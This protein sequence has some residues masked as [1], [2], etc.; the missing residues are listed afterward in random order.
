MICY[1]IT[2]PAFLGW[3][4]IGFTT[5]KEM[6]QRLSVY[7]TGT[8]FRDY[9]VEYEVTFKD[10]RQAEKLVHE[11]LKHMNCESNGEWFKCNLK[12]ACNIIDGVFSEIETMENPE[13]LSE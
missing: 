5:K 3:V 10:P 9:K 1:I 13:E 8:P 11:H 6:K 4:K 12:I 2:N 7:Q